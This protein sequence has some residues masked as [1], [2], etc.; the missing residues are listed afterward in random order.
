MVP[1]PFGRDEYASRLEKTRQKMMER[2]LDLLIV[3]D[4]ANQHYLTG[5]DGWSFYTPQVVAV[6][7]EGEPVWIGRSVDAVGG[8]LTAWM[9]PENVVGFPETYVQTPLRHPMDWV[10]Q[11]IVERGWGKGRVG[12]ELEA[13]Y[14]SPKAHARLVAAMP[15][16]EFIDADLL[17]SWLRSVKSP[18]EIAYMR[19]AA[20]LSEAAVRTAYEVIAPGVRECDAAAAIQATQSNGLKDDAGDTTALPP[21]LLCGDNGA[22]PHILW[23]NRR[24]DKEETISLE[25]AGACHHYT[26]GLARTMQLGKKQQKV[27]D[28]EK[29][30]LEGMASVLDTA[31]PG[32]EAQEVECAWRATIAKHG[33]E[34]VSRIGYSIGIGYSPD[35]GE[36][37]ISLRQGD[38]SVLEKGNTIHTILGMWMDGWGIEIS[39]T[40]HITEKG[41]ETLANFPRDIFVKN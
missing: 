3:T 32:V 19:K 6:P 24:F 33:F 14:Y 4:V 5:Y 21:L 11:H 12:I 16:A 10:G 26:A 18:A 37:T 15:D 35:W 34:K 23:T 8:R 1:L 13:Y 29:A 31:R 22:A 30:V 40:I 2:G 27:A 41:C 36:H 38:T 28:V 17:V 9:K 7:L 39:E 25:I 20:K